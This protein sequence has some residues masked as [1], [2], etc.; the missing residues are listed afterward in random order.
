ME[1]KVYRL[2]FHYGALLLVQ[3]KQKKSDMKFFL[4]RFY[5]YREE[6]EADIR[7][8]KKKNDCKRV[9]L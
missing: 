2:S 7:S 8:S 1:E 5:Y 3:I 6:L 4:K 9:T